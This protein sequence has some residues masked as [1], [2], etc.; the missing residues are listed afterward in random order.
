MHH[1][2]AISSTDDFKFREC[3]TI[4]LLASISLTVGVAMLHNHR[5]IFEPELTINELIE[6]NIDSSAFKA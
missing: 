3:N 6:Y 1:R 5:F 2:S 4:F